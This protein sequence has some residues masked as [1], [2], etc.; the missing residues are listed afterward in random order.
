[1]NYES[2]MNLLQG[3]GFK[4]GT[5]SRSSDEGLEIID[6]NPRGKRMDMY[7]VYVNVHGSVEFVEYTKIKW[8]TASHRNIPVVVKYSNLKDLIREIR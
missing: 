8:D 4:R 3:K 2:V 6:Y 5:T 7:S 1:M